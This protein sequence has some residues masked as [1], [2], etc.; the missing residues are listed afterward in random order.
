LLP[1]LV[2]SIY[3]NKWI[4]GEKTIFTIY[5]ADPKGH[6][7][8]LFESGDLPAGKHLVDIWNHI[9]IER[10]KKND[11]YYIPVSI[12][13][14]DRSFLNS[15]REGNAGC[16]GVFPSLLHVKLI[17]GKLEFIALTGD[18]IVLT[19][20]NP[21][22]QSKQITFPIP[23]TKIAYHESFE[24][25]T[26]KI[27]IQLFD[28]NELLDERVIVLKNEIPTRISSVNKTVIPKSTPNG[29]VEIPEGNFRFYS[30][31]DPDSQ[32]PFI[33]LPDHSDTIT[34]RMKK[35]FIDKYPV[36][37]REFKEFLTA[38]R[39][40]P[41]DTT[42]FLKH[43][44]DG[45]IPSG[46]EDFPV[47][48]ISGE[49][50]EAYAAWKKKRLPTEPEWQYA[51]QGTDMRKY[52][53]GNKMDSLRCNYKLNHPTPVTGYPSGKSP[54]GVEDMI[55]NIW[56]L[57]GDIYDIGSYRY[58]MIKGGSYYRPTSSIWYV[59]GGPLPAD[60][61]EILLLIAPGLDRNATVGFRC[62]ADGE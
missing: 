5:S 23:G 22:Y 39:Y 45:E 41:D 21:T 62:V 58:A 13:P 29:M 35:F 15:R 61:P 51:A 27:V 24:L 43:W 25:S 12:D 19:G 36:T 37:N 59:T 17:D 47:V 18:K 31:R 14:F 44:I 55:G 16:I 26:E 46:K 60:H 56:Q 20:E 2:D 28:K 30:R 50:A 33:A 38:T 8:A 3:V 57:T 7:G 32:E 42:N 52:P 6:D 9:E 1:T 34:I 49:D 4:S 40:F 53:W 11:K 10:V 54:F 48:Y